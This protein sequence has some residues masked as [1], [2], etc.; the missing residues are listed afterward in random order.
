MAASPRALELLAAAVRA[1]DAT[2][3]EDPVAL[4]VSL[5]MPFADVFLIVT[6]NSERNVIAIADAIEDALGGRRPDISITEPTS[7]LRREGRDAGRWV[8]LDFNDLVVHVFHR[9]DRLYYG[10]E[11]LWLDCPAIPV[12][13][14]LHESAN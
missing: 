4:D 8:L 7:A 14:Y 3:A 9:E 11:R 2:G 12:R 13:E 5:P 10:L 1:A 6:G